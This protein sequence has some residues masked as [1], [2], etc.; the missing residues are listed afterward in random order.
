[1]SWRPRLSKRCGKT[2]DFAHRSDEPAEETALEDVYAPT[3]AG[4]GGAIW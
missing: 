4:R 1:M 3:E 2:V